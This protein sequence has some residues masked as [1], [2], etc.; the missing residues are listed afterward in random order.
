M[1][2]NLSVDLAVAYLRERYA[3]PV[4][5]LLAALLAATGHVISPGAVALIL[6]ARSFVIAFLLVLA[7]RIGDDLADATRDR[8]S[9]P[10]RVLVRAKSRRPFV[11]L[12]AAT[13][14]LA[15]AMI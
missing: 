4:F 12:L 5:V 15:I 11:A 1:P 9:H 6:L 2:V 13:S 3:S 8:V 10:D 7:F 14:A